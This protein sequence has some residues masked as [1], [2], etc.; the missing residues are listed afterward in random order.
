MQEGTQL[1]REGRKERLSV[2]TLSHSFFIITRKPNGLLKLSLACTRGSYLPAVR[3]LPC[4]DNEEIQSVPRV[5]KV[6]L[7]A[8]NAQGH[9]LEHHLHG[10]EDE[11]EVIKNLQARGKVKNNGQCEVPEQDPGVRVKM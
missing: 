7:L 11:D 5:P 8:K 9:H 10:K 1:V 4:H 3:Y 6:A 2:Q